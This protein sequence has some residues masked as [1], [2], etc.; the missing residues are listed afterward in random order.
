MISVNI[1]DVA[2]N[3]MWF[4]FNL[5]CILKYLLHPPFPSMMFICNPVIASSIHDFSSTRSWYA[6]HG[7]SKYFSVH[8]LASAV[9]TFAFSVELSNLAL[10]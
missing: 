4:F 6:L 5:E 7:F 2:S 3:Y 10:W 8:S 1:D 9:E